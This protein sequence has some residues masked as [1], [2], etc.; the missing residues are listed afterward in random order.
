LVGGGFSVR[1]GKTLIY[2]N[3][4]KRDE[5]LIKIKQIN[6]FNIEKNALI[7]YPDKETWKEEKF[8]HYSIINLITLT[9]RAFEQLEKELETEDHLVYPNEWTSEYFGNKYLEHAINEV[10][11]S[12]QANRG[13]DSFYQT[14]LWIIDYEMYFGIWNKSKYKIHDIKAIDLK[15]KEVELKAFS[16]ALNVEF[17]RLANLK[18]SLEEE[19]Q[20]NQAF[21]TQKE[22]E[23]DQKIESFN[24][25]YK[26]IEDID[27]FW[28]NS[29]ELEGKIKTTNESSSNVLTEIQKT[30][31]TR[32]G[33]FEDLKKTIISIKDENEILKS[34]LSDL[35]IAYEEKLKEINAEKKYIDE[36]KKEIEVLTGFAADSSLGHSFM[37]RKVQLTYSTY[38]WLL[39]FVLLAAGCGY[40]LYLSFTELKSNTGDVWAD[41]FINSLKTIPAFIIL[42]FASKQ[43]AKERNLQEDYAFKQAVAVTI[44]AYAD[45]LQGESIQDRKDLIKNTVEKIYTAP[46]IE[47][48]STL[49]HLAIRRKEAREITKKLMDI[50]EKKLNSQN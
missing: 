42:G 22:T 32:N 26:K 12:F 50:V 34:N 20:K 1:F 30:F 7:N 11:E 45:Q 2:M 13:F 15:N 49:S 5:L 37:Q 9:K 17:Q 44:N 25:T 43:Y 31:D 46:K 28:Q 6:S 23:I 14:I 33:E 38:I 48:E 36:K 16:D 4:P 27:R 21:S 3:T 19:R 29:V 39:G 41:L 10:L 35:R 18:T 47:K 40:W 24:E 8:D